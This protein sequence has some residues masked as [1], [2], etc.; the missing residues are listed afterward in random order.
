MQARLYSSRMPPTQNRHKAVVRY[1]LYNLPILVLVVI[2]LILLRHWFDLADWM[3]WAV[4][5]GWVVKDL[6]LFP[7]VRK[8][9]DDS[10][11][12]SYSPVGQVAVVLK[13]LDPV[14]SVRLRGEIWQATTE[15]EGEALP[16]GCSVKVTGQ[17]GMT[18]RVI[19]EPGKSVE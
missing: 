17:E 13:T 12:Y 3:F 2:G 18:L 10:E 11:G 8:A 4:I 1:I 15:G 7:F 5:A 19:P 9:Y 6:V 16:E 14:G